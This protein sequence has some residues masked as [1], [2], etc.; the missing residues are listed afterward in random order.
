MGLVLV[1]RHR[2][3]L[4]WEHDGID[5]TGFVLLVDGS[6]RVDLGLPTPANVDGVQTYTVP[7]P[8]LAEGAH[9]L[10][11]IAVSSE[12]LESEQ[13]VEIAVTVL[14]SGRAA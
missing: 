12:G 3:R 14:A 4:C 2:S 5:V 7:L 6:V 13:S 11:V 8:L 1:R 10:A 9:T